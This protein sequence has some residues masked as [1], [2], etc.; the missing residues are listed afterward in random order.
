MKD[1]TSI[2]RDVCID[3]LSLRTVVAVVVLVVGVLALNGIAGAAA[4]VKEWETIH[5]RVTAYCPCEL[6]CGEYA[7]GITASGYVIGGGDR[8]VA[9]DGRY[10]FGSEMVIGD[11]NGGS[12]VKV[13]DRGGVIKGDKLDVFFA[14]HDEALEWGV[15]YIDVEIRSN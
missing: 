11:Y 10:G 9:A 3:L 7:D 15:Q 14:T 13:L 2:I 5:M 4:N 8:F 6:C 1:T 12:V